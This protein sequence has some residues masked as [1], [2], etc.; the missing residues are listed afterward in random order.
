MTSTIIGS[1]SVR[2]VA[3]VTVF[4]GVPYASAGRFGS[5][6]PTTGWHGERDATRHGP[7]APQ[8]PSRLRT[9]MGDF[10]RPQDEDCQSLTIATPAADGGKRAVIVFL[11]GGA[12]LSGAGSLDWYD[13]STL[14][15]DGD[16]VVVGV[17][18]RLGALGF[19]HL[20]GVAEGNMGLQDMVVALQWVRDHIAAFGG[21]PDNVTVMGQSAGAHAIM[22]LLTMWNTQGLFHRAILQSPPP[23]LAPQS[24]AVARDHAMQLC[25]A[26]KVAPEQLADVPVADLLVAQM[27]VARAIARFGEIAPPFLPVFDAM[28]DPERFIQAAA[29]EAAARQVDMI[30]GTTREEMHAFLAADPAMNPPDPEA[31]AERFAA[32]SGSADT[33]ALYRRR[34]PGGN[35]MDLLADLLTD[36]RFLFP[37]LALADAVT[38]AGARAWTY[39]FD[40]AP[41]DSIFKACHCIELPFLF[42]N[43][44]AWGAAPML[45]G[46]KRAEM[47]GLS[48]AMRAA[49]VEFAETGDPHAPGLLW[50][51]YRA[52]LRQTMLFGSVV[53][54]VG[55][56]SGAAWRG[57]VGA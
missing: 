16:V 5:P 46:G 32:L 31:L 56:P 22:C 26:L 38:R 17:N 14:A 3:G 51:P 8:P 2:G 57:G 35:D 20:P 23:M 37:A 13:A 19:L 49:W 7:I 12:Y 45:A 40:W 54:V 6:R 27:Q 11:H 55:D 39:Q 4:R 18:Y 36:H 52:G 9:A 50:P 41:A 1:G 44:A 48:A 29:T 10:S 47:E 34:R 25:A 42:G 53:G 33:I 24:R 21:D 43:F 30:I 28:A 15:R